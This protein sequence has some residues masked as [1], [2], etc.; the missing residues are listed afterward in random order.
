MSPDALRVSHD[1]DLFHDNE[2]AVAEAFAKD[3]AVL[4]ENGFQVKVSLSQPGFIRAHVAKSSDS[5]LVDWARDSI[6]RFQEPVQIE[7]VGWILHPVDL[8]INKV[9]AL[10]G[11]DEPRD[12][13][14]TLYL[15]KKVLPLGALLWA[16]SGK[17]R[18]VN[19]RMLLELLQRKG[20]ITQEEVARLDL[21]VDLEVG[22]LRR[23]WRQALL[24]AEEWV[25]T[26]PAAE[27]GCLYSDPDT[28]LLIAPDSDDSIEII[29]GK[30]GGVLPNIH[31]I[32]A[33][34]FTDSPELRSSIENFFDRK[35][36][37]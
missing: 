20:Q 6:W 5:L 2:Q 1:L 8:A 26:R 3:A 17:D 21:R 4:E 14:D 18:G 36:V 16:A 32:P 22:Q 35:L 33:Q 28:G 34:S 19:P 9:L 11:R 23:D 15:H 37:D 24:E 29:R 10:A 7:G 27:V 12:F 25:R 31:G 30:Q 13:L